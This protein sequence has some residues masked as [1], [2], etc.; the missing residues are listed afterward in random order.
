MREVEGSR[1]D[2]GRKIQ[3]GVSVNVRNISVSAVTC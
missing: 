3:Q 2:L 1:V